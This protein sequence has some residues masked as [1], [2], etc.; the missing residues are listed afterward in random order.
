MNHTANGRKMTKSFYLHRPQKQHHETFRNFIFLLFY[1][2]THRNGFKSRNYLG[3]RCCC[4][5]YCCCLLFETMQPNCFCRE[6]AGICVVSFG[7]LTVA[8]GSAAF[9]WVFFWVL[10]AE[11]VRACVYVVDAPLY[12][13]PE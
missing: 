11:C 3:S 6:F 7:F 12:V 13:T 10:A 8:A 1:G 9:F 4:Y 5:Y 2:I